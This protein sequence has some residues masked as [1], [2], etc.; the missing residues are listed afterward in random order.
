A[1]RVFVILE[2]QT[3]D[4]LADPQRGLLPPAAVR[5]DTQ[6]RPRPERLGHERQ[7]RALGVGGEDTPLELEDA[8]PVALA[9]GLGHRGHGLWA[10]DLAPG[11]EGPLAA[12]TGISL[13]QVR[14]SQHGRMIGRIAVEQIGRELDRVADRPPQELAEPPPRRLTAGVEAG[15][16]DAEVA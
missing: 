8:E 3:P 15:Q 5:V 12:P 6:L 14:V 1:D 13:D 7:G 9:E 11:V 4:L 2:R 16:L 10:A